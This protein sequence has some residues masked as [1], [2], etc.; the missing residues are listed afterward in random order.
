MRGVAFAGARGAHRE[1]A[2]GLRDKLSH[3]PRRLGIANMTKRGPFSMDLT[4]QLIA[5]LDALGLHF[6]I[7]S[8]APQ[9]RRRLAPATLLAGLAEQTDGQLDLALIAL[10]LYRPTFAQVAAIPAAELLSGQQ[11]PIIAYF[12]ANSDF[13]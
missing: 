9:I 4:N 8:Q 5:E 13:L 1:R 7:G 11:P 3:E 2:Q 12:E 10:F 6:V